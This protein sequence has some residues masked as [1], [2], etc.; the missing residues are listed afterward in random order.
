L[1][2]ILLSGWGRYPVIRAQADSVESRDNVPSIFMSG[3]NGAIVHAAGRSYG[4]SALNNRVLFTHRLNQFIDFDHYTGILTIESGVTLSEI[5]DVLLPKGWFLPVTPGT[6][7]ITIGGAVAADVHGKNHHVAGCFSDHVLEL[8]L[9]LPDGK[10][11]TC[12]KNNNREFFLA[13]C[14]GMGLTGIIMI[15]KIQMQQ[16]SSA[17]IR[18]TNIPCG[19]LLEV[20]DRFN[21]Y[22]DLPYSVA[23]IDCLSGG[24]RLGRSVMMAGEHSTS[25]PLR[26]KRKRRFQIPFNSPAFFLNRY[27]VSIF[28]HLYHAANSQYME[29]RLTELDSFFYPLDNVSNWNRAYGR[30]G[31]LQ[32]QLVLPMHASRNGLTEILKRTGGQGMGSFLAVLKLFGPQNWN[33]LSF[34]MAGYTLA[35]DF[36]ISPGVFRFLNELDRIVLDHEGR[37]YLAKDARMSVDVFQKGYPD[38]KIFSD[39]RKENGMAGKLESIQSLRLGI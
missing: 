35:M 13:T 11:I 3:E 14:G 9:M 36:K 15:V 30:K 2:D 26:R 37:L 31:F 21:E 22:A 20:M 7:W 5:I 23:W 12:G 33:L 29:K 32:Y 17:L 10:V 28:N 25:G 16:V 6:R 19:N 18:E 38:W 27:T 4:D 1:K 24:D 34:P 8:S 39:F